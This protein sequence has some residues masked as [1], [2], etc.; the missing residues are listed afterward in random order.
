MKLDEAYILAEENLTVKEIDKAEKDL[1]DV[2]ALIE[3]GK[4]DPSATNGKFG[5][6]FSKELSI[7]CSKYWTMKELSNKLPSSHSLKPSA[8]K[9][10]RIWTNRL[11][12][13]LLILNNDII[14]WN[15]NHPSNQLPSIK[16]LCG[17]DLRASI[18]TE[19]K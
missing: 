18:K 8:E 14:E 6:L 16:D 11:Y 15:N 3:T 1:D 5:I 10:N 2:I 13:K 12:P 9:V 19:K 7:L 4:N 17:F